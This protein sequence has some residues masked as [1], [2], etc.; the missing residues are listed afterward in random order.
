MHG[1]ILAAHTAVGTVALLSFWIAALAPKG[2]RPHRTAGRIYLGAM[3]AILLSA[4][5]LSLSYFWRGQAL[6]G[7]F[8]F[9]LLVLVGTSVVV[10][11]RAIRLKQDFAAFRGGVYPLLAWA[12]L[13]AGSLTAVVGVWLRQPLLGVFGLLGVAL[14]LRMLRLRRQPAQQ[15]GWWLREHFTAMIGNGVATHVAFLG[16]GLQRLLPPDAALRLQQLH[17]AWFGPLGL[18]LLAAFRLNRQHRRRFAGHPAQLKTP[19]ASAPANAMSGS[20]RGLA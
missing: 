10:A 14:A 1:F 6:D 19:Q 20:S 8:F 17:L 4:L 7:L 3:A 15:A 11:P 12:Q 13:L 2:S 9:D 16:I 5:P 18:A